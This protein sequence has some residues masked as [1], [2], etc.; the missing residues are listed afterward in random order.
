M[1]SEYSFFT[2]DGPPVEA[3]NLE[4][5]TLVHESDK[6]FCRI[7]TA[8]LHGRR[9]MV[10]TL[11]PEFAASDVHRELLYKEFIIGRDMSH[12]GIAATYSFR[13][14]AL[15]LGPGIICE[16][17]D[18]L[19]LKEMLAFGKTDPDK[20]RNIIRQLCD[21][22]G[23]IHARQV[24]HRDMKPSNIML[25]R[26]GKYVKIIDFGLSDGDAYVQYK[27][28]GGTRRYGA[29]E[30][31]D[32]D[33]PTDSRAD[34]YALGVI[35][36]EMTTDRAIR[37]VAA[38]CM[39]ADRE[40]RPGDV[41]E[42]PALIERAT[43]H[44][45]LVWKGTAISLAGV[46]ASVAIWLGASRT[47]SPQGQPA[48]HVPPAPGISAKMTDTDTNRQPASVMSP[49]SDITTEAT[50]QASLPAA[51]ETDGYPLMAEMAADGT[52][53]LEQQV[54]HKSLEIAAKRFAWQLNLLDT[55]TTHES[56]DLAYVGH[57][58]W[59]AE[60]DM[61]KWLSQTIDPKS[62]Y[63][64]NLMDIAAKTIEQYGK[65]HEAEEYR[66]KVASF[67]RTNMGF[68]SSYSEWLDEDRLMTHTLQR[69]GRWTIQVED[70]KMK[71][72]REQAKEMRYP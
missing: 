50:L 43:K 17:V 40:K 45:K 21:A 13:Q 22:L 18:G 68:T 19:T 49:Q 46:C 33:T 23:Y 65:D 5:M 7:Y 6:G 44:R 16:Y 60:Q 63:H 4:G 30:Q 27:Y 31:F 34:I 52:E 36:D 72:M 35:M 29:P 20:A 26:D 61:R 54:Y 41:R 8:L 24:I 39:N 70:V 48:P 38:K 9:V 14:D 59:L 2:P 32:P 3:D 15:G 62:P 11:K 67:K 37:Q 66:H 51:E 58:K 12:P 57:W 1:E 53:P 55:L 28:P 10:K 25:T 47:Q 69:D 71:R 64:E 42:I 56:N